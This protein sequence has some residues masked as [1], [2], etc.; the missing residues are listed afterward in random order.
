MR[1]IV[2]LSYSLGFRELS[3]IFYRDIIRSG[4]RCQQAS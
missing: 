4:S 1:G 2:A 3:L